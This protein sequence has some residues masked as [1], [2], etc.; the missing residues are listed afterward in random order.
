M[1]EVSFVKLKDIGEIVTGNTPKTSDAEN[2]SS[3]DIPFLKPSDF[4]DEN[5]TMTCTECFVSNHA[6]GQARILPVDS[7]AVTCIGIIGKVL[8]TNK[9][10]AFNQQINAIIPKPCFLSKYIAYAIMFQRESL[11]NR[12]N[13]AVVPIINKSAFSNVQIPMRSFEKQNEMVT[14]LDKLTA[15]I[16][17]CKKQLQKLDELV[18]SRFI[19]MFADTPKGNTGDSC[20]R[21]S[22]SLGH[23]EILGYGIPAY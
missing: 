20:A 8:V 5:I 12:A 13:A 21:R 22:Y 9:E 10:C 14:I 23:Y 6:K 2:Y 4:S 15:L 18:K 3:N 11:Q 1:S 7:I 19:E 17:L 16:S